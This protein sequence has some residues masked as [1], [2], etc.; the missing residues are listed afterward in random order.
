M[1]DAWKAVLTV[2]VLLVAMMI[3]SRCDSEYQT[4]Y[5]FGTERN[6]EMGVCLTSKKSDYSFYMGYIGFNNLR[7]NIAS[8]WDKELG[9]VYANTSMAILDSKKYNDRI[10][11]IL[12]DDRFKNED[13]DIADFLFQSDCEGKCG[14]K[15][16]E[17]IYNLIK[18]IDFTGKI[19]TYAAYSDGKDYEHLKLFLKECYKK[20]R[21]MIW[22]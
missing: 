12:A 15:T 1:N 19:F 7:A 14:Y 4:K 9:E 16:C 22:Y 17:K 20:R 21:M 5:G 11:S 6:N 2:I 3:D 13:E 18:D 8:A 10:N